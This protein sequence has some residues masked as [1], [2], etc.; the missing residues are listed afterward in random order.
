MPNQAC[1]PQSF[2]PSPRARGNRRGRPPWTKLSVS[3]CPFPSAVPSPHLLGPPLV[4]CHQA[5]GSSWVGGGQTLLFPTPSGCS[6]PGPR[7]LLSF[8]RSVGSYPRKAGPFC[9]HTGVLGAAGF[10]A[11]TLLVKSDPSLRTHTVKSPWAVAHQGPCPSSPRPPGRDPSRFLGWGAEGTPRPPD[12]WFYL[13]PGGRLGL[14]VSVLPPWCA[15]RWA[16]V[17]GTLSPGVT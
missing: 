3:P 15:R 4:S 5:V 8:L 12:L 1:R 2:L 6:V 17:E 13:G 9:I 10:G 16:R 7:P 14:E 11:G